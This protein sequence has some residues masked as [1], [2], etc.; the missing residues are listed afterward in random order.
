[1]RYFIVVL[2]SL[3]SLLPA[4]ASRLVGQ[5]D[6]SVLWFDIYRASLYHPSGHF[7]AN[8]LAETRLILDYK[9]DIEA[10]ELV[11][12]TQQQWQALGL[13]TPTQ[14]QQWLE[15]LA[16]FWPDLHAGDSLAFEVG[17]D[18]A[19]WFE[20]KTPQGTFNRIG[21]IDSAK[22]SQD[23]LAIWLAKREKS[24]DFRLALLG[25]KENQ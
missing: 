2:L 11:K 7:Q 21:H 13:L 18:G 5:A 4:Y 12:R 8:N 19:G 17:Q 25:H 1:M 20:H 15:Q 9:I 6:F 3:A 23:F 16:T 22:F 14:H 10:S 24:S